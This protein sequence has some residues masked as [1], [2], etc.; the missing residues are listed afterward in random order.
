SVPNY[1]SQHAWQAFV[2]KVD[3]SSAPLPRNEIMDK[4][5]EKG[6]ATRPGTHAVH[7]LSFYK[8]KY[9]LKPDDFPGAKFCDKN[10]MAI[11]LHNKMVKEDFDYIIEALK[12]I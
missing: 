12:S 10:T 3:P 2:C 1:I 11:P 7:M 9:G 4:L 5:Q 6:I 8:D